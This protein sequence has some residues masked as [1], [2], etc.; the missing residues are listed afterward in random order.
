[1]PTR[2]ILITPAAQ[3]GLTQARDYL[4][5]RRDGLGD[6]F[7]N[8][9]LDVV[10]PLL[11]FPDL[12]PPVR[13]KIRRGIVNRFRYIFTYIVQDDAIVIARVIHGR[14]NTEYY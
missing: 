7:I 4:N 2:H 13:G 10:N 5:E 3:A 9:F 11:S 6:E 1:M 14:T 12:Y 8:D